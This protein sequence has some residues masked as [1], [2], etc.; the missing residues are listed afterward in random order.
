[1]LFPHLF[2]QLWTSTPR[3]R[4]YLGLLTAGSQLFD[5]YTLL[6]MNGSGKGALA[7]LGSVTQHEGLQNFSSG[8]TWLGSGSGMIDLTF[9][10]RKVLSSTFPQRYLGLTSILSQI[11]TRMSCIWYLNI[12][13]SNLVCQQQFRPERIY[14]LLQKYARLSQSLPWIHYGASYPLYCH[15]CCFYLRLKSS[16]INM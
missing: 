2:H 10:G 7:L 1:M 8:D 15:F 3:V 9:Y 6:E 16:T 14:F 12:S 11:W 5:N 13:I 4:V